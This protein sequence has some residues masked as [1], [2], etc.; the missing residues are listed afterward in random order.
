MYLM[1]VDECGDSGMQSGSSRYFILSGMVVHESFWTDTLERVHSMRIDLKSRYGFEVM[2]E[3]HAGEMIG[4]TSKKYRDIGK[5]DR[6]M[7]FR[8][9]LSF[10]ATL[11]K[12]R[13]I[14]VVVDKQGKSYGFDAFTTAWDTIIN[15][16]ENT[17]EHGNFPSPYGKGRAP[18]A[19]KG[20]LIVDETD[21]MKL[22]SLIRR[23]RHGNLI[24]SA[25]RHGTRVRHDLKCVIEDPLH[26]QSEWSPLIQL[27]DANSYFLKQTIEPNKTVLRYKAKNYFY[28]L[29]PILLKQASSSN[30]YGIVMR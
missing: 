21:E 29:E 1:Y 20:M 5:L 15:R 27:C 7:M 28:R 22:R 19:E 16:F 14:N 11:E 30:E 26:K 25:I 13:I 24:P 18:F 3:L 4:R 9:V 12:V 8:D 17:M 10:E 23:M 2:R 6:V